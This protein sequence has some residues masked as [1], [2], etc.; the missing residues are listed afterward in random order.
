MAFVPDP[1][2]LVKLSQGVQLRGSAYAGIGVIPLFPQQKASSAVYL[3]EQYNPASSVDRIQHYDRQQEANY[4]I[5]HTPVEEHSQIPDMTE[6]QV[7]EYDPEVDR[8]FVSQIMADLF[9]DNAADNGIEDMV[10]AEDWLDTPADNQVAES[11]HIGIVLDDLSDSTADDLSEIYQI[12]DSAPDE[13]S[14]APS[15]EGSS[16]MA[17]SLDDVLADTVDDA[18]LEYILNE[19]VDHSGMD[20][21]IR[22]MDTDMDPLQDPAEVSP[23]ML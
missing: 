14:D 15:A 21:D 4:P 5:S 23:Y 18:N 7:V 8:I 10:S 16:V 22:E 1:S 11:E 12:D 9:G 13:L 3:T 17:G 20:V 2:S 19:I 6:W